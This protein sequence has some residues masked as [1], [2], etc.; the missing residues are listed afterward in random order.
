MTKENKVTE[1]HD[2]PWVGRRAK[3]LPSEGHH[4]PGQATPAPRRLEAASPQTASGAPWPPPQQTWSAGSSGSWKGEN[5]GRLNTGKGW[6]DARLPFMISS[7]MQQLLGWENTRSTPACSS[8][9]H[10]GQS[11]STSL[12]VLRLRFKPHFLPL[13]GTANE[14]LCHFLSLNFSSS[15]SKM[16]IIMPAYKTK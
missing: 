3:D 16:E 15:N 13:H 14:G 10:M 2:G 5:Q 8:P 7:P 4:A 1:A 6:A 9:S 11:K 12:M